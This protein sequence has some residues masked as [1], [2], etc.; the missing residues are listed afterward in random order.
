[1][2]RV[3]W[4]SLSLTIECSIWYKPLL[5]IASEKASALFHPVI[6]TFQ[7]VPSAIWADPE[8]PIQSE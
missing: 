1:M 4:I 7:A 8:G 2:N 3:C 6:Q 5:I